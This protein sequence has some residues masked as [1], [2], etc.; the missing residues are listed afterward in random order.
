M[1]FCK[2]LP[3]YFSVNYVNSSQDNY[4]GILLYG[5]TIKFIY[6]TTFWAVCVTYLVA[7]LNPLADCKPDINIVS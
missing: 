7:E 1:N 3:R 6:S 4:I 2:K 5:V